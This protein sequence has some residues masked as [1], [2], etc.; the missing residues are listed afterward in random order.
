MRLLLIASMVS[1][2]SLVSLHLRSTL[3]LPF[4]TPKHHLLCPGEE[5]NLPSTHHHLHTTLTH[6]PPQAPNEEILITY[7]S[8]PNDKLLIHYG[9][10][11][12]TQTNNADDD[13]RLDH[14]LLSTFSPS[15]K[16][17]LQDT[18]FLGGYAL[19]PATNEVC[20]KTHVAVRAAML[21]CNEWEYFVSGGEDLGRDVSGE[22]EGFVAGLLGEWRR[23]R[24]REM[25]GRSGGRGVVGERW[26]QIGVGIDAFVR[27]VEEGREGG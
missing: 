12:P 26:R 4:L 11:L 21:T 10:I 6:P 16:S 1:C 25:E 7:G 24:V 3:T 13:I 15:I 22:V 9:F 2:E 14:L 27:K 18:G 20:F 19:L 17:R 5:K 23:G 8:H